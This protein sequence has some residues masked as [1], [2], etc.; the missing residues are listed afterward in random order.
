[1]HCLTYRVAVRSLGPIICAPCVPRAGAVRSFQAFN[2]GVA[3]LY[4][5]ARQTLT[6]VVK[7]IQG[8]CGWRCLPDLPEIG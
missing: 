8:W 5:S 6:A 4:V 2:Y 7:S 3:V 1:M